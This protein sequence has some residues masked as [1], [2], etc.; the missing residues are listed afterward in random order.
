MSIQNVRVDKENK[1]LLF[2]ESSELLPHFLKRLR[3]IDFRPTLGELLV[4]KKSK[5]CLYFLDEM[6][7]IES[8][9]CGA[10]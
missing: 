6:S 1:I 3:Y 5:T 8:H 7:L 9:C 4:K 10:G 2:D